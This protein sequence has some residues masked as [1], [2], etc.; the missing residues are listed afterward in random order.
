MRHSINAVLMLTVGIPAL[1]ILAS[2]ATLALAIMKPDGEL[3]EQYHWEGMRL[4]RDFEAA[5]RAAD[6][7]VEATLSRNVED[8]LCQLTL[9]TRGTPPDALALVLTHATK[10]ALDRRLL[11]RQTSADQYVAPCAAIPN[12]HWRIELTAPKNA[13]SVRQNV[14]GPM[15][16]WTLAARVK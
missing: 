5:Q 12:T 2:F 11:L 14:E 13:W 15:E 16:R 4:D 10:P 8:E 3:P 9:H 7:D 1:A 6:L